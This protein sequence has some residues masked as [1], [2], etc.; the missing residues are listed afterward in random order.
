[1]RLLVVSQHYKPEPFNVHETCEELVRRGHSVTVLTAL[2]NCPGGKV[3]EGYRRGARRDEIVEGV[4]VRRVPIVARGENLRGLNKLRRVANYLSFPLSSW[5]TGACLDEKYDAVMCF[6]FS[7]VLMALPALRIAHREGIPC[8]LWSFDLW[9]EDMLTGGMSRDGVPYRVMRE[10]SRR[11]YGEADLLAVTSPG[12]ETYFSE[13][14]GLQDTSVAWLPQ[15]AETIFEGAGT[16]PRTENATGETVFTFAGNVGGNQAVETIVRAAALVP[17]SAKIKIRIVGSGSRL[18]A[19]KGLALRIR[20][21]NVEF[22][23]RMPLEEMPKV[24]EGSDAMLLT[25][26]RPKDGSLVS[27]YTIPRKFQSY[28]ATGCPVICAVEGTVS[29]IVRESGCGLTCPP[30]DPAKLAETMASFANMSASRRREMA[31]KARSLYL[32]RY[33][34]DRYFD[35]LGTLLNQ[36]VGDSERTT[37]R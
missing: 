25:L 24:Y 4:R 31:D 28:I 33:S 20:A 12:F 37:D 10:V 1:M 26:S 7:P 32:E 29:D 36:M 8:L 23:G 21:S 18:D 17:E 34:R 11:I 27:R 30:E 22:L 6:Q 35:S 14:L 5:L 2:P 16:S 13:Q 9:P 3:L 19:C 15:F